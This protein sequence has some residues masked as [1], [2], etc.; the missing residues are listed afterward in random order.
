MPTG[1]TS[2]IKDGITFKEYAMGCARAFGALITM[3]DDPKDAPIP[4][5]FEPSDYNTKR[6][7][8]HE[9]ELAKVKAMDAEE[10]QSAALKEHADDVARFTKYIEEASELEAKYK[11]M[12]AQVEAYVS[13]SPDHDNFK[14]F[15][16]DQIT[17]SIKFDCGGNYHHDQL[18]KLTA[19]TP[20][21]EQWQATKIAALTKDIA[22]HAKQHAEELERTEG[23]N[24]WVRE[25]RESLRSA[26]EVNDQG[27]GGRTVA[28]TGEG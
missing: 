10:C 18:A 26:E 11:A 8:E 16:A 12:L 20:N 7:A 14:K 27:H 25:L 17:E 28:E 24:R 9:A 4:E 22:Y 1:Y 2:P 21:G 3:R 6:L 23:R 5:A 19:A 13:P 15:M